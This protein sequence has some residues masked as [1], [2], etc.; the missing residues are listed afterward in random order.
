MREI[1]GIVYELADWAGNAPLGPQPF[2]PPMLENTLIRRDDGPYVTPNTPDVWPF[3]FQ[4]MVDYAVQQPDEA[5]AVLGVAGRGI[6]TWAVHYFVALPAGAVFVQLTWGGVYSSGEE[7]RE[8]VSAALADASALVHAMDASS[9]R[10]SGERW[11]IVA[12]DFHDVYYRGQVRQPE[13][14]LDIESAGPDLISRILEQWP[15]A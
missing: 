12:S 1:N 14:I 9:S 4:P 2:I 7:D 11:V 5:F 10:R 15:S 3:E 13:G 6:N 8:R